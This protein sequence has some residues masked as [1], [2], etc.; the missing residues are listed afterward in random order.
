MKLAR[1]A[2]TTTIY[3]YRKHYFNKIDD[4]IPW[5]SQITE[6]FDSVVE[7]PQDIFTTSDNAIANMIFVLDSE[8]NVYTRNVF[9]FFD[10]LGAIGGI[11]LLLM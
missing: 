9:N 11:E 4:W 5:K 10:W 1:D 2:Y 3:K 8:S 6:E 7:T